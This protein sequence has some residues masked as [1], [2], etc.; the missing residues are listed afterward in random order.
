MRHTNYE[1][2]DFSSQ[3]A[4]VMTPALLENYRGTSVVGWYGNIERQLVDLVDDFKKSKN[5][6]EQVKVETFLSTWRAHRLTGSIN[7]EDITAL[8]A[9]AAQLAVDRW[10][11]ANYFSHLR[12]QLRVLQASEEELPREEPPETR[13]PRASRP[14]GRRPSGPAAQFGPTG[15][16][17]GVAPEPKEAAGQAPSPQAAPPTAAQPPA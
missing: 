8:E 7:V 11:A 14:S 6:D 10:K 13:M 12:D 15:T 9:A 4:A 17:A 3:R 5:S 1:S 16:K 2:L